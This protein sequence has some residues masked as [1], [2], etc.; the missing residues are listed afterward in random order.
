MA[1]AIGG[2][3]SDRLKTELVKLFWTFLYLL[4]LFGSLVV[5]RAVLLEQEGQSLDWRYGFAALNALIFAKV[6]LI[7]D[8]IGVGR[9]AAGRPLLWSIL[10]QAAAF[11]A[12]FVLFHF[13]E[14]GIKAQFHG[15][16]L[17]AGLR[18][19]ASEY[20]AA[21]VSALLFAVALIPFFALREFNATL[22]PERVKVLLFQPGGLEEILGVSNSRGARGRG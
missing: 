12:L 15:M 20:R 3:K 9:R 8:W 10:F 2:S 7:G 19:F 1:T 13:L 11:G 17:G 14:E 4:V 6:V 16:P 5:F 18:A 21:L 22:G